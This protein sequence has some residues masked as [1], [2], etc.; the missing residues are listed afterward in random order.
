MARPVRSP[1]QR[2]L[3]DDRRSFWN[4]HEF[5]VVMAFDAFRYAMGGKPTTFTRAEIR[6]WLEIVDG[7]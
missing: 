1:V 6:R 5:S 4:V 7:A 2:L 3:L